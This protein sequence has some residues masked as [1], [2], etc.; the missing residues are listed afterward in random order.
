MTPIAT[1]RKRRRAWLL[2][3]AG[4][5][6]T[7][8]LL[9]ACDEAEEALTEA[10][11]RAAVDELG[12]DRLAD[13]GFDVDSLKCSTPDDG[14]GPKR[15]TVECTGR[16][17]DGRAIRSTGSVSEERSDCVRGDLTAVVGDRKVFESG[18]LGDCGK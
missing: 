9:T 10:A 6:L 12:G 11:V 16:T 14:D 13:E 17:G 1:A 7:L 15:V 8:G 5:L 18:F 3:A 4:V 2:P